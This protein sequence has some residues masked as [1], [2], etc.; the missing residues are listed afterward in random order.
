MTVQVLHS[1]EVGGDKTTSKT[2]PHANVAAKVQPAC[3]DVLPGSID[4][5][6]K[7][8][9]DAVCSGQNSKAAHFYTMS[10]NTLAKDMAKNQDGCASDADLLALNASSQGLLAKLLSNRSWTYLKLGDVTAAMEDAKTC[11]RASPSFEKGHLRYLAALEAAGSPLKHQ[12]EVCEHGLAEC[13]GSE[14]LVQRKWRLKKA[15]AALP[16]SHQENPM[17]SADNDGHGGSIEQTRRLADD[18]SDPRCAMAAADLG[19]VLAVGAYG[20]DKDLQ[21]AERYL[22]FAV[23]RGD[24][25]AQRNLGIVLLELDQPVEASTHLGEAAKAGDEEAAALL[26][27]LLDEASHQQAE[28][29]S[30]LEQLAEAG[31]Q[32]A[33][34]MLQELQGM[35]S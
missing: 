16:S 24:L 3:G 9:D 7:L 28:A 2:R 6:K 34:S 14:L 5:L 8:A 12:L 27:Q 25:V 19:S 17:N 23:E 20:I 4:E 1:N 22:R 32:R 11:T 31:D 29:R 10:I 26:R 35:N 13:A 21:E 30:K 18:P 15:I 33:M